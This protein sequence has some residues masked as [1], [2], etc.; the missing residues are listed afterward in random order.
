MMKKKIIYILDIHSAWCYGNSETID[1]IYA[2]FSKD[3]EFELLVGSEKTFNNSQKG[4]EEFHLFSTTNLPR[5]ES[6]TKV[7]I[8]PEYYDLTKDESY[9]FDNYEPSIAISI[10]KNIANTKVFTFVKEIQRALFAQGKRLDRLDNYFP[11]L[12]LLK[13][14]KNTFESKWTSLVSDKAIVRLRS[15]I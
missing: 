2:I 8:S 6:Y 5:V 9:H 12:D 3:V 14:D 7:F 10:I 15:F 1:E 11:I 13:I 4:G